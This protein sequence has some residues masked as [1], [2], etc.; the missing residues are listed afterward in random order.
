MYGWMVHVMHGWV[1][2]LVFCMMYRQMV[3]LLGFHAGNLLHVSPH[4][5]WGFLTVFQQMV[6]R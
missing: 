6:T 2:Q 1:Q 3:I 4:Y 5:Y